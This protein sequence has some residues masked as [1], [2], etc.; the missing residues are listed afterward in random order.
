MA[1]IDASFIAKIILKEQG[2][3]KAREI[4]KEILNNLEEPRAPNIV[5]AE[6]LNALWK[7]KILLEDIDNKALALAKKRL[8]R[9]WKDLTIHNT[10][11]LADEALELAIKY[12]T[13]F[14]DSLYIAL[15]KKT[16]EKLYTFD[17]KLSRKIK[18]QDIEIIV[19]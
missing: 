16:N 17:K 1:V 3:E 13:P 5:L 7:H 15:A 19:L 18:S 6:V 12:K 4:L 14:Y 9:I 8:Y 10:E 2:S 11:E